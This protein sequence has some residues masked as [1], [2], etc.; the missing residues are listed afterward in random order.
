MCFFSIFFFLQKNDELQTEINKF[1]KVTSKSGKENK[2]M[3]KNDLTEKVARAEIPVNSTYV[4]TSP[5]VN[6]I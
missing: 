3:P 6:R 5:K 2:I 4:L 1:K